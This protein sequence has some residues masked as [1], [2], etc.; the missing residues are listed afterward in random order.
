[1]DVTGTL[2]FATVLPGP[3]SVANE[4]C[5]NASVFHFADHFSEHSSGI[6]TVL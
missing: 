6:Q 2:R 5:Q 1:M 3:C 4:D